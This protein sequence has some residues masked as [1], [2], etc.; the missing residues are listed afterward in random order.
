MGSQSEFIATIL[1]VD[2]ATGACRVRLENG[3]EKRC[4]I[5]DPALR[6]PLNVYT[7][8]LDTK[9]VV[10]IVAQ[11]LL[12]NGEISTLINALYQRRQD[13]FQAVSPKMPDWQIAVISRG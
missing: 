11:P 9:D 8:A 10:K 7:H 1:G 12:K 3:Q 4:K 2:T 6:H 13:R 5:T